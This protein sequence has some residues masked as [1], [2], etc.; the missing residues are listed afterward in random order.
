MR[1]QLPDLEETLGQAL[2]KASGSKD[3]NMLHDA[4]ARMAA[5]CELLG[6]DYDAERQC[7]RESHILEPKLPDLKGVIAQS[8]YVGRTERRQWSQIPRSYKSLPGGV[9]LC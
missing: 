6:V 7:I 9:V 8:S 3:G 1:Q 4:E 2:V 5:C